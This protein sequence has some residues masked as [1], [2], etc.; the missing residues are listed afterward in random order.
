MQMNGLKMTG[1]RC[2]P[3]AINSTFFFVAQDGLFGTPFLTPQSPQKSLCG[4]FSCVLSQEMSHKNFS[5][6]AQNRGGFCVGGQKLTLKHFISIVV[7]GFVGCPALL[8]CLNSGV[9]KWV[10][11]L[12]TPWNHIVALFCNLR[13][14]CLSCMVVVNNPSSQ[15]L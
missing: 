13:A 4:S 8:Q 14:F 5:L 1:L 11:S 6:W 10:S 3:K 12:M 9:D 7:G 2:S 15:S